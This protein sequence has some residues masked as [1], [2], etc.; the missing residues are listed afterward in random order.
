MVSEAKSWAFIDDHQPNIV[1][2]QEQR[3][4]SKITTSEL[5]PETC[6]HSVYRKDSTTH[7][8]T[9]HGIGK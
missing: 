7:R 5:F 8:T 6:M 2:I 9:N 3:F 4:E 1:A